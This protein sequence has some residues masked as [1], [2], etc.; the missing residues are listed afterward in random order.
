[1]I[2]GKYKIPIVTIIKNGRIIFLFKIIIPKIKDI[3]IKDTIFSIPNVMNNELSPKI[4]NA[5]RKDSKATPKIECVNPLCLEILIINAMLIN[6]MPNK[7]GNLS[8]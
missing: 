5:K 1:M 2:L 8:I 7:K 3:K 4:K 6:D